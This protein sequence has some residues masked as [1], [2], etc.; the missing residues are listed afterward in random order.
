MTV[1]SHDWNGG[2]A[3]WL[4]RRLQVL[5]GRY[6][7]RGR[8]MNGKPSQVEDMTFADDSRAAG[9]ESPGVLGR[10]MNSV[11]QVFRRV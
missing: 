7:M 9:S 4:D 3:I 8:N 10:N 11:T 6:E 5:F 2:G 1:R